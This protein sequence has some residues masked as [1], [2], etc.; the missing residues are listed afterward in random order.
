MTKPDNVTAWADFWANR[1]SEGEARCMPNAHR[2][3]TEVQ[4]AVWHGFARALEKGARVLDLATGDGIVLKAMRE[5]R[6]DLRL[7]GVDSSPTLP[8]A[9]PGITL[10]PGAAME[11]LP[12]A[13]GAFDAVTSQFGY[14]YGDTEAAAR[15][16]A[17][18][19]APG[20]SL[21]FIVHRSDGPIVAHNLP[22]RDALRWALAPGGYVAKARG[23]IA[24]RR[25]AAL[26]TPPAF[27]AA[28]QEAQSLFPNQS[29]GAEFLE[30]LFRTLEMGRGKPVRESL[31]VI[32]T[33]EK[34][35]RNEIA[36]IETLERA[37]RDAAGIE[38][39]C[40]ELRGAGFDTETPEPLI[41]R[42]TQRPFAWLIA[43][44]QP[45]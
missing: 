18:I 9:P 8:A 16:V 38:A 4:S 25:I 1:P 43:G 24:A 39:L 12:F 33:L 22:R 35:A 11:A 31:E 26:P 29:V 7:T 15:E 41:E 44:R 40:A 34:K 3:I 42:S 32:D 14:E 37:A 17:R 13:D 10:R 2:E 23:L 21:R 5:V 6:P 28:P 20:G 19:L 27:R 45:G 30:A 36:R